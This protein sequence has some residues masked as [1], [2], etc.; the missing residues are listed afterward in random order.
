MLL[1]LLLASGPAR[2]SVDFAAG[3]LYRTAGVP[4]WSAQAGT[5][6]IMLWVYAPS[7]RGMN[8]FFSAD[9]GGAFGVYV[10]IGTADDSPTG[11]YFLTRN[12]EWHFNR[13]GSYTA[14]PAQ[15]FDVSLGWTFLAVSFTPGGATDLYAWQA[16]VNGDALVHVPVRDSA[17]SIA[18]TGAVSTFVLGDESNFVEGCRCLMGPVYVYDGIALSQT[19]IDAQRQQLAPLLSAHLIAYSTFLDSAALAADA[20]GTADWSVHGIVRLSGDDPPPAAAG[21]GESTGGATTGASAGGS[22]AGSGGGA[23]TGGAG[24]A[25]AADALLILLGIGAL[26]RRLRH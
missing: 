13:D 15:S 17:S 9:D 26:R 24:G 25:L 4:A 10:N 16:G 7:A 2:A 14:N 6:T 22:I 3:S 19:Q 8:N 18:G 21:G 11:P 5:F 23:A 20:S 1:G 12:G